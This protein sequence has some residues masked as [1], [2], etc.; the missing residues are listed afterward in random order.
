MLFRRILSMGE[1]SMK[2][3]ALALLLLQTTLLTAFAAGPNPA[4]FPVL[5]H[6]VFTRAVRVDGYQ[7][8]E[9][10]IDGQRV[11]LTG[12][13]QGMLALG[14]YHARVSK[15]IRGPRYPNDYDIYKGYD[16]LMSDGK[17]RTYQVTAMGSTAFPAPPPVAPRKTPDAP[18][19]VPEPAPDMPPAPM[20]PTP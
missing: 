10:M 6:V 2:K 3:F 1:R 12:L 13:S 15:K 4:D 14:D 18:V 16:F 20:P 11:E 17:V 19:P 8:I 7:Q 9:A 5:V